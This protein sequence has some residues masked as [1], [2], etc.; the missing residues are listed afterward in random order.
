MRIGASYPEDVMRKHADIDQ[1]IPSYGATSDRS[2][3]PE[4]TGLLPTARLLTAAEVARFVGCHEETVRRAY[5]RG[6]LKSQRFGEEEPWQS[7]E[8]ARRTAARRSDAS[9]IC[10]S[11]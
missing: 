9:N 1:I 7:G 5:W 11:T 6:L 4:S 10:G 3:P 8:G 2:T